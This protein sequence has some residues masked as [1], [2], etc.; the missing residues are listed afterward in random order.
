MCCCSSEALCRF[1]IPTFIG[2][3]RALGRVYSNGAVNGSL[4]C[5][6][7]P[8]SEAHSV[9][10]NSLLSSPTARRP[11]QA[12]SQR[13]TF[14]TF[15]SIVP[16]TLSMSILSSSSPSPPRTKDL[17][18]S[19][20]LSGRHRS[21]SPVDYGIVLSEDSLDSDSYQANPS[22]HYLCM[23]GATFPQ[24]FKSHSTAKSRLV[25]TAEQLEG[26]LT[27]VSC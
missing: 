20:S 24:V 9:S 27:L 26:I 4:L 13:R 7:F 15:R 22:Q 8:V 18:S 2:V 25:F 23:I 10:G 21:P 19:N 12:D 14:N 11:Q 3:A 16:R 5:L 1:T 6:L 17:K